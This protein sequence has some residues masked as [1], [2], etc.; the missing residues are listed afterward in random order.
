M[1]INCIIDWEVYHEIRNTTKIMTTEQFDNDFKFRVEQKLILAFCK[2]ESHEMFYLDRHV[3]WH[4]INGKSYDD[5]NINFKEDFELLSY[6]IECIKEIG[7]SG[8]TENKKEETYK[9]VFDFCKTYVEQNKEK[10][11][12]NGRIL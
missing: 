9:S 6:V 12:K 8:I 7:Y 11:I 2:P 3:K 4:I 10:I 5:M 1:N